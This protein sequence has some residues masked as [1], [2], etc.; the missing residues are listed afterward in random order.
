M[1]MKEIAI[2][3]SVTKTRNT[4]FAV[5]RRRRNRSDL[6]KIAKKKRVGSKYVWKL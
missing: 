6:T 5:R 1:R 4:G 3:G 2:A